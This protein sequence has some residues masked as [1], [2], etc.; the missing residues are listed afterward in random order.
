VNLLEPPAPPPEPTED[1]RARCQYRHLVERWGVVE[2]LAGGLVHFLP[3]MDPTRVEVWRIY[4]GKGR[5][6]DLV[7]ER[8]ERREP[9]R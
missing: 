6:R 4:N 7:L 5:E 3:S 2:D 8:V 1:D 9:P